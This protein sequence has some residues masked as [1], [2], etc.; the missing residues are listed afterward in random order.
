MTTQ[1]LKDSGH[2]ILG[3]VETRSDGTQVVTD[4][5]HRIKGYFEPTTNYTKDSAHRVVAYGNVLSLLLKP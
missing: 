3:Y 2:R 1:V 5:A 4:S